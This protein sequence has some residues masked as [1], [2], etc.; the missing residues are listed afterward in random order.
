MRVSRYDLVAFAVAIA[1]LTTFVAPAAM[2]QNCP[3]GKTCFYVPPHMPPPTSPVS[4][5]LVLAA[6]SGSVSGTY[7]IAGQP[8]Q[9]FT[10]TAGTPVVVALASSGGGVAS[11]YATKEQRGVFVVADDPGLTVVHREVGGPW[12]SSATI[13]D[14]N[15][16]LGTRFRLGGYTLDL[17]NSAGSGHDVV[18]LYAPLGAT[19]TVTPPAGLTWG[20]G[21]ATGAQVVTL[22]P[23]QTYVMRTLANGCGYDLTGALVTSDQPI[24]VA[25]GGRGWAGG[26]G[27][28]TGG[29]GDDG[30]DN[31]IPTGGLGTLYAVDAYPATDGDRVTVVAD[32]PN[33]TVTVNGGLVATLQPGE[34]YRFANSGLTVIATSEPAYVFQDAGEQ[35]C[36]HGM[37]IIPPLSFA[38][39][40]ATQSV[41]FNVAGV[42]EI[43]VFL[44]TANVASLLVDGAA[45]SGTSAALPGLPEVTRVRVSGLS[46]NHTV[47]ASGDFHVGLVSKD[48][49]S[50]GTGLFAYYNRFRVPGCGDG[51]QSATEACD[52]GNVVDGDGCSAACRIEIGYGP[53]VDDDEC[54][55]N[56]RC[57]GATQLCV[58][59]CNTNGDCD[60]AND[61]TTDTCNTASGICEHAAI[62][63]GQPCDDG[64]FCTANTVCDS[65]GACQGGDAVGCSQPADYCQEAVCDEPTNQCV[66]QTRSCVAAPYYFFGVVSD[67]GDPPSYGSIRC[68][69]AAGAV[70]CDTD[71]NGLIVGPPVCE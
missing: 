31:L 52:D 18:S 37:S 62:N 32:S 34:R 64:Q 1:A 3:G 46:G 16:A 5:D 17:P 15:T 27:G 7:T 21:G 53:C 11:A 68:W 44:P 71:E 61:C 41:A 65:S 6:A 70:Q 28:A 59:R 48:D 10:A 24:A 69:Y 40:G 25:S 50:G 38:A 66:E 56:G 35:T 43:S 26:C 13:K 33:T 30:L 67:G 49:A 42:G 4:W 55:A 23:Q 39:G 47:S 63:A 2:A 22:A 12:N 54:V 58:A 8:A 45:P 51:D 20:D 9:S 36:E 29:C 19:I 57:D 14:H 60:D